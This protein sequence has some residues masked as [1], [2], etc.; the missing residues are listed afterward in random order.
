[1]SKKSKHVQRR[2][3]EEVPEP[4]ETLKI[5]QVT[6][7]RGTNILEVRYPDGNKILCL[8]PAKFRKTVWVKKGGYVMIEPFSE[9]VKKDQYKD[10]K[11]LGRVAFVLLH[12]QIKELKKDGHWP[13]EFKEDDEDGKGKE[14]V[15]DEEEEDE[16]DGEDNEDDD[17]EEDSEDDLPANPNHKSYS[18]TESEDESD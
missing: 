16:E 1:M 2:A 17:E 14:E 5:V 13:Q 12:S 7:I 9:L 6:E 10:V 18:E 4:N 11:L 3:L 8:M 15:E